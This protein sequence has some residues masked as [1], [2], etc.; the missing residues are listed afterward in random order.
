M[1]EAT[2][3]YSAANGIATLTIN[4]PAKMNAMTYDMWLAVPAHIARA[5]ADRD[6]R[7]IVLTGAG[8]KAFC[9][10]ADISQFG[11]KRT[12]EEAV[13][14]YEAAVT[15]GMKAISDADKPTIARIRGYAFGGG[16]ALA[17]CTDLRIAADNA[18]FRIPA[19]RLGLGYAFSNIEALVH[20]IGLGPTSDLLLTAR[21]VDGPEAERLGVVNKMWPA[22]DF[23]MASGEYVSA[24][25]GNAPLTLKAVKKAL[26]ETAKAHGDRDRN[27]VEA[28]VAACFASADYKEG[29][30]AF[31][32][33]RAPVF[34]GE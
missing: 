6:I 5:G 1:S 12:G 3:D 25:A 11:E 9:A 26:V 30:L 32:E 10:G 17:M 23:E 7:C 24:I 4:Q 14:A 22:A 21:I 34:R 28:L 19:A 15:A 2:V 8:E 18:K 13:R 29:Q 33:K 31:K 20:R 16:M 27:A